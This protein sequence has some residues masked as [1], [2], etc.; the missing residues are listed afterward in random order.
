MSVSA[1]SNMSKC[2]SG[3]FHCQSQR[4]KRAKQNDLIF[5]EYFLITETDQLHTIVATCFE[6]AFVPSLQK[7]NFTEEETIYAINNV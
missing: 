5:T 4:A 6:G 3:L 2:S 1:Q 7:D